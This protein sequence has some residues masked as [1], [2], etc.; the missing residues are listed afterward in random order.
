MNNYYKFFGSPERAAMTL[1][2]M[3]LWFS[4]RSEGYLKEIPCDVSGLLSA[5]IAEL[6]DSGGKTIYGSQ[7]S[8]EWLMEETDEAPM[9]VVE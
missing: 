4:K 7:A 5:C 2:D 6:F 1:C 8:L 3:E 9:K